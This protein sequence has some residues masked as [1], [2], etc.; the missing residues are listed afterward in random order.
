MR[1][2]PLTRKITSEQSRDEL[3]GLWDC[4]SELD[5][6]GNV[7]VEDLDGLLVEQGVGIL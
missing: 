4:F 1:K 5:N 6:A 3:D 7:T 2:Y